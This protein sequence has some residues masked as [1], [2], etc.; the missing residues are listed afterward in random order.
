MDFVTPQRDKDAFNCPYCQAYSH[1]IWY[2]G[3]KCRSGRCDNIEE[4]S[5]ATC[6]R[7]GKLSYWI[8]DKIIYPEETG[9]PNPNEDL[10]EEIKTD[11]L[12]AASIINK[13]PR[14]AAALLRLAIQKLC[15]QLG[16]SGDNINAD[17]ANL[18]KNGLPVQV[19]RALDIVRVIG[20]ESVHPGTIDLN[21]DKETAVRLFELV[22]IIARIM[23]TQ[24]KEIENLYSTLPEEKLE[25]IKNRD[26]KAI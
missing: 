8:N 16:E 20:N 7:C 21:D 3:G 4:L 9:I 6:S 1:Q 22:N 15:K 10:D 2:D 18:V 17:I 5:I 25:G 19:Q 11:Y 24:P 13:S 26:S 12:E 14:G 23:I